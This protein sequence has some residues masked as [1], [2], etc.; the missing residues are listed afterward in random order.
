MRRIAQRWRTLLLALPIAGALGF[1]ATQALALPAADSRSAAR[2]CFPDKYCWGA[3][4][5]AGG[6]LTWRGDCLCCEY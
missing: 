1:G 2:E 4:P 5:Y 6:N 3:C